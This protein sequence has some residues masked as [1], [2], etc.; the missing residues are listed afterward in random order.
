[1]KKYA[2]DEEVLG[3]TRFAARKIC[4]EL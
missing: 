2:L 3:G 1:M 4:I